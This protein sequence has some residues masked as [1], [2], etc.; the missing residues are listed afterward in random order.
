MQKN[1]FIDYFSWFI[2]AVLF[3]AS[4]IFARERLYGDSAFYLFQLV[5]GKRFVIE[6]LRPVS[7]FAQWIPLALVYLKAP[8]SSVILA[9]SVNEWVYLFLSYVIIAFYLKEKQLA[10]AMLCAVVIGVRWNYFNPV[11][12]LLLG[13]PFYFVF[14]ILLKRET[15]DIRHYIGI[16][17]SALLLVFS[18]PLYSLFIPALIFVYHLSE[19]KWPDKKRILL[20]LLFVAFCIF[21]YL[22]MDEYDQKT[23]TSGVGDSWIQ[24]IYSVLHFPYKSMVL[25][26]L[27]AFL[28]TNVLLVFL[29]VLLYRNGKRNLFYFILITSLGYLVLVIFL[30][31]QYFPNTYEPFERYL[32]PITFFVA[33][34]FFQVYT[35]WSRWFKWVLV[36]VIGV[37]SFLLFKYGVFVKRRYVSFEYALRYA[38]QF[39]D[40]KIMI[41][42]QNYF[43]IPLGHD[44]IMCNESLILSS[45]NDPSR[46]KQLFIKEA[47]TDARLA[48]L[49][50]EDYLFSPWQREQVAELN[51]DYF[52]MQNTPLRFANTDSI[53][54]EH[55]ASFFKN[56]SI[57]PDLDKFY[58]RKRIT[59]IPVTITN[60]NKIPLTS[61][62]NL[63]D[64]KLSY[65]WYPVESGEVIAGDKSPLIADVYT[66]LTQFFVIKAPSKPGKYIFQADLLYNGEKWAGT[67]SSKQEVRIY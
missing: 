21:H 4:I 39:E 28:G 34:V 42:G 12:E 2:L 8:M 41:S 32:Y 66:E 29:L 50:P 45:V 43:S 63:E 1:K 25:Q 35:D 16:S 58:F 26:L 15:F 31:G 38:Q 40:D 65:R 56:I 27:F 59:L 49:Q 23:A 48:E 14:W 53:Q 55:A 17:A 18:H 37:H 60:K 51:S 24:R 57:V 10:F 47:F 11:S 46:T 6:H 64:V 20:Y 67:E 30:F 33:L 19:E 13:V 7:V 22:V 9:F 5:N 52:R 44:W 3:V 61:G 36:V 62:S 54:S